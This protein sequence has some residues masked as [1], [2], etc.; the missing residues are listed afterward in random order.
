MGV[1]GNDIILDIKARNTRQSVQRTKELLGE[2]FDGKN[3]LMDI[4]NFNI[5]SN[6]LYR[7]QKLIHEWVGL[8]AYRVAGYV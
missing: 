4:T 2:A 1:L 6:N 3:S 7:W 5:G 8:I